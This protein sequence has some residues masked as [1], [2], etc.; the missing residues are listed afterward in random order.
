MP[1]SKPVDDLLR[2]MQRDQTHLAIVVDEYG[3]T[4]G[5][6]TIEDILEEIVGEI[7][8]EYDVE[9]TRSSTWRDGAYRVSARLPVEDLGELFD[10]ELDDDEVDT[11]GGLLA[12]ALGRVPIPGVA[13]REVDGAASSPPSG[14]TGRRN[15]I[16]T[17]LVQA[18]TG[19]DPPV[20]EHR[21]GEPAGRTEPADDA[22]TARMA[23][24]DY[25]AGF[26]CFVGRPNA[27]KSTLTNALV[28]QKVAITSTQAADHPARHPRHR[29]PRR[30][31]SWSW[32]TPPACTGRARCSASGS[33]TWSRDTLAEVD[34]V[35]F[36]LPADEP[37]GP[38]DRFIAARREL[39]QAQRTPV[40]AVV[41]KTDLVDR[42]ALG[43]APAWP[44]AST[45][46]ATVGRRRAGVRGRRATRST[47]S[48]T[49]WSPSCRGP[50]R[51]TPTA[52]SPTSPRRSWSP[53]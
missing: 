29:A 12:K 2:E 6:V 31:P 19:D 17:V 3:G 43:R 20:D 50:R 23:D 48:P 35:G 41:T 44:L 37:V 47:C 46:S 30:T 10:V 16:D 4:A 18:T 39:A 52:S 28:G 51:S 25:R 1:E 34:V 24:R 5:L 38:G 42:A 45:S 22:S 15:R 27:G 8:D 32:S 49:C 33:T 11:V 13:R 9:R 26:A 36:C 14:T 40:V 53:S 21:V 7:T